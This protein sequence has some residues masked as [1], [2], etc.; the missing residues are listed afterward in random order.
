[1]TESTRKKVI[2][3]VLVVAVIWGYANLKP[4]SDG[5]KP[6]RQDTAAAVQPQ[7][8]TVPKPAAAQ[9]PKL[10]R[11]EEKA[12]ES[13]GEDPFR[14]ERKHTPTSRTPNKVLKWTLSGILYN[15]HSP[16]AI[17]NRQQVRSGGSVDG[18]RVIKIDRKAVTLE[19][20]GKQMTITV[21]KG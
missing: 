4:D 21:T 8:T 1:M 19:H 2:S 15:S 9:A 6:P 5:K 7:A 11:I 16:I 13:W 20:N 17:I 12:K 14:V 18:A 10:V 3:G